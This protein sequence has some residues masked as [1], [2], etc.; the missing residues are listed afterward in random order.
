MKRCNAELEFP[1]SSQVLK[2]L[3]PGEFYVF[4]PAISQEVQR[5]AIGVVQTTHP[6]AGSRRQV[7]SPPAP[8]SLSLV[9]EA[10]R[11]LP[12][13]AGED[14]DDNSM[15]RADEHGTSRKP[16]RGKQISPVDSG[17]QILVQSFPP[18]IAALLAEKDAEI[19]RLRRLLEQLSTI[20][21]SFDGAVLPVT[22]LPSVL[23]LDELNAQIQTAT[24]AVQPK[25][26]VASDQDEKQEL[27][28]DLGGVPRAEEEVKKS[29]P[30]GML[31]SE[32]SLLKKLIRQ[33]GALSP[34]EK[35]LF[36]WLIEHDGREVSSQQLAHG[37]G[38]DVSVT[39]TRATRQLV[40]IPFIHL[41]GTSKFWFKS[42]FEAYTRVYFTSV[43]DQTGIAQ[44]L[45]KAAQ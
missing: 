1:S 25:P 4:G 9:L 10:L 36:I 5:I 12:Q 21:V 42:A 29:L 14:E 22:E 32:Q 31:L 3:A 35:V 45:V 19:Q 15:E 7:S 24:I 34:S 8:A 2:R 20:T 33:V 30:Q 11:A 37:V 38:M 13:P 41:R 18:Q 39:W 23:H 16:S 44:R 28:R 43:S 40:K 27:S 6:K 26:S 17:N